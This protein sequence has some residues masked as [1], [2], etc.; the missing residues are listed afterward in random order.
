[1]MQHARRAEVTGRASVHPVIWAPKRRRRVR[2]PSA[3]YGR[4]NLVNLIAEQRAAE[5]AHRGGQ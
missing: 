5:A 2:R 1:M 3:S 4:R